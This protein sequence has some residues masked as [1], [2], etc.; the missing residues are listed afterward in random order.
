MWKQIKVPQHCKIDG[1]KGLGHP[2]N[3]GAVLVRRF[4]QGYCTK[5]YTRLKRHGD[6]DFTKNHGMT[7]TPEYTSWNQM[8]QRCNSIKHKRYAEWG[9]RGIKV[10]G[11][12]MESFEN[13]LEDMGERP[14]DNYSI[15]RIDN[16]GDY[17]PENCRWATPTQQAMNKG[18]YKNNK[19]GH[20]GVYFRVKSK[21]YHAYGGLGGRT[22]YL[23]SFI[24][25][26]DA[27]REREKFQI[28][29]GAN[30]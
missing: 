22:V 15:D 16:D 23:G 21:R 14:G 19:T 13:F 30:I 6:P 8:R 29:K 27:I 10:C 25:L 2:Y 1:C 7:N 28:R 3:R 17:T 20:T 12:W 4:R 26:Q 9:G 5:H 18:R 11:R 24:E